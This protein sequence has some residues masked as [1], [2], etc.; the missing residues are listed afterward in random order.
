MTPDHLFNSVDPSLDPHQRHPNWIDK[1][2]E[3]VNDC[4]QSEEDRV[5][6]YTSLWRHWMRSCWVSRMWRSY[7]EVDVYTNLP[8]PHLNGWIWTDDDTYVIDWE[9]EGVQPEIEK[10]GLLKE[11]KCKTKCGVRC[12]C[13]KKSTYCGPG[14][15]CHEC[16]NLPIE[17]PNNGD[18]N[19]EEEIIQIQTVRKTVIMKVMKMKMMIW[20]RK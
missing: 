5:P 11:C 12:G 4:I 18:D 9:D 10:S 17:K 19:D 8:D 6:S 3:V 13:R 7:H 2:R 14:C 1:I 20:K 15:E 16:Q